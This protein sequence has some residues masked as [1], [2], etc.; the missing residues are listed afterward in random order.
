MNEW[1]LVRR[2]PVALLTLSLFTFAYVIGGRRWKWVRRVLGAAVLSGG[3]QGLALLAHTW[4]V[5]MLLSLPAYILALSTGYGG[6]ELPIKLRRRLVYGLVLGGASGTLL[7]PIGA[8]VA[9]MGQVSLAVFVSVYFGLTNP[10]R[11]AVGEE[12]LIALASTC[13]VPFVVLG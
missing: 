8:W 6:D 1:V 11:S 12:S 9:W 10:M 3:A 7:L 13:V 4:S 2:V 5:W